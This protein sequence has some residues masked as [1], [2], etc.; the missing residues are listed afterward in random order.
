MK[1]EAQSIAIAEFCG[2]EQLAQTGVWHHPDGKNAVPR[3]GKIHLQRRKMKLPGAEDYL[4]PDYLNDLNA[5]HGAEALLSLEHGIDYVI[6]LGIV[7]GPSKRGD[8]NFDLV[9]AT[10]GQRAEALLR[11]IGKWVNEQ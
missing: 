10:A 6:H 3:G 9:H 7:C 1:H 5:I 2:W 8:H 4:L 11:V